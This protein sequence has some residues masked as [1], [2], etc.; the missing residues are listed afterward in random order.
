MQ[1]HDKVALI[2]G[3]GSGIGRATA[4]MIGAEGVPWW[5]WIST[6]PLSSRLWTGYVA[7]VAKPML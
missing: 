2:S 6:R 1:C 3:A 4:Q 7:L 5:V